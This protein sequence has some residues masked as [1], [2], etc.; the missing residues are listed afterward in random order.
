MA[1]HEQRLEGEGGVTQPDEPVIPVPDPADLFGEGGGRGGDDA[2]GRGVGEGLER[3]QG[4]IDGVL[5]FTFVGVGVGPL[6]PPLLGL[7]E[8]LLGLD[9][10]GGRAM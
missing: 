2:T 4:S 6:S 10:L 3:D 9:I 1:R 7:L 5:P 8:C